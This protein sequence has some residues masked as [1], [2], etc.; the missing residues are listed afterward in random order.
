MGCRSYKTVAYEVSQHEN[1][2]QIYSIT[3]VILNPNYT[4]HTGWTNQFSVICTHLY[5]VTVQS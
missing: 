4:V 1:F 5:A 2:F 3:V